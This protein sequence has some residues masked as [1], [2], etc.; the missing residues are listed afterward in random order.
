MF[1]L[2]AGAA[3]QNLMLALAAQGLGSC[4]LSTSIFCSEEAARALGLDAG[5]QAVG[6]VVAGYAS[7]AQ[8]QRGEVD[9]SPFLDIR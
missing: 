6:C 5:W 3:V 2:S 4:W 9:P 1:L 7:A 8:A